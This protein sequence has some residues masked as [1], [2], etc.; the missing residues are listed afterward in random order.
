MSVMNWIKWTKILS[1]ANQKF[2]DSY[3]FS[4]PIEEKTNDTAVKLAFMVLFEEARQNK[5]LPKDFNEMVEG[6]KPDYELHEY[7]M[8]NQLGFDDFEDYKDIYAL[9]ISNRAKGMESLESLSNSIEYVFTLK[10][11]DLA[12]RAKEEEQDKKTDYSNQPIKDP[13]KGLYRILIVVIF[14]GLIIYIF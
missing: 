10:E 13:Y 8:P 7:I 2:V 5:I 6:L 12:R 14:F 9:Y 4:I 11:E 3:N 1:S